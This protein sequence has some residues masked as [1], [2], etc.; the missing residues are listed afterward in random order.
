MEDFKKDKVLTFRDMSHLSYFG[1]KKNKNT[2]E[3]LSYETGS[4][5]EK[6]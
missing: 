5:N 1:M 4:N 6:R 3:L 2:S